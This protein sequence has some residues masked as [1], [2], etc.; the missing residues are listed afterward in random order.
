MPPATTLPAPFPERIETERLWLRAPRV[1]DAEAMRAAVAE[2]FDELHR[3]MDWARAVPSLDVERE[4][5][6]ASRDRHQSGEEATWLMWRKSDG[7]LVGAG[8]LPR[9]SWERRCFEIGYWA[10]TSLVGNGYVTE[11]ATR[12]ASLCFESLAARRVE[13]RTSA[14]NLRSRRVAELAGFPLERTNIRDGVD[15][16]GTPRNTVVYAVYAPEEAA[17]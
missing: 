12:L 17:A 11:F 16:D 2:A 3:W 4:I 13:I 7:Q 10:R 1:D 5:M 14:A 15:P 8:G 6:G 9:L